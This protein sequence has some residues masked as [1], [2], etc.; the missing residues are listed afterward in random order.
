MYPI[1]EIL[2]EVYNKYSQNQVI[3]VSAP[4]G[5]GKSTVLPLYLLEHSKE[6]SD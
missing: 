1:E 3:I 2:E 5:T 6:N 4:T